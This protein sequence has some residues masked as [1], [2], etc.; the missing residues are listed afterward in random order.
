VIVLFHEPALNHGIDLNPI[1]IDSLTFD[2]QVTVKEK[3]K[4]LVQ[5]KH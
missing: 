5:L 4:A 1:C 3:V 2:N